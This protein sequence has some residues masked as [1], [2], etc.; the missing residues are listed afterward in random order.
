MAESAPSQAEAK[1][2]RPMPLAAA[3]GDVGEKLIDFSP[4]AMLEEER[5][6]VFEQQKKIVEQVNTYK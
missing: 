4:K 1:L 6:N 3:V 5:K 2:D